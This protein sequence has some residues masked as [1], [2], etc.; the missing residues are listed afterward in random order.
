MGSVTG[1]LRMLTP[2][3]MERILEE[4]GMWIDAEDARRYFR[5]AGCRVDDASKIVRFPK[6]V[7]E[8]AVRRMKKRFSDGSD[9]EVWSHIRYS[10]TLWRRS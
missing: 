9:G 2:D 4:T 3:E 5:Q 1:L 8:S 6:K 7:V 10:R